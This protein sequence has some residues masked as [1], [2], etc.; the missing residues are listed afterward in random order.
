MAWGKDGFGEL[1]KE[2]Q[3]CVSF[4]LFSD[5]HLQGNKLPGSI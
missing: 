2:S 4:S 5:S 3:G 1:L